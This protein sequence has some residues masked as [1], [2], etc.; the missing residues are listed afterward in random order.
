L[1]VLI[2]AVVDGFRDRRNRGRGNQDE[3]QTHFLGFADRRGRRHHLCRAV[4]KY[5]A[6]FACADRLVYVFSA[7]GFAG[8]EVTAWKH[9]LVASDSN[10]TLLSTDFAIV[11]HEVNFWSSQ[12]RP[13]E[14]S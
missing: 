9:A 10:I 6:D 8:G 2:L 4:R 12:K 3:V 1:F 5:G 7:G 13:P 14:G 11:I